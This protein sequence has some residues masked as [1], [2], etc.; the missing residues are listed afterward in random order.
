[1]MVSLDRRLGFRFRLSPKNVM[2]MRIRVACL[3]M[4]L[5]VWSNG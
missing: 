1:M 5:E 4:F 2:Q 3:A